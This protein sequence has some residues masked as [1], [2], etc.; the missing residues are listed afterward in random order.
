MVEKS[1]FIDIF[2]GF[3]FISC[4]NNLKKQIA[5]PTLVCVLALCPIKGFFRFL[6]LA[7]LMWKR[8]RGLIRLLELT[9]QG[10]Q[11]GTVSLLLSLLKN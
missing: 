1:N 8:G 9:N 11:Q 4:K 10:R 7:V 3:K 2:M 6:I 5:H